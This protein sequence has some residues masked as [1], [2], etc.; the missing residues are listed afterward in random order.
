MLWPKAT[1]TSV[2]QTHD[3]IL[4]AGMLQQLSNPITFGS[5]AVES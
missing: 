3:R 4:H 5:G 2:V 1:N